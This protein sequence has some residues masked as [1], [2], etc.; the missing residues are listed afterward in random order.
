MIDLAYSG[1]RDRIN[2]RIVYCRS[3]DDNNELPILALKVVFDVRP[4]VVKEDTESNGMRVWHLSNISA[5]RNTSLIVMN[6]FISE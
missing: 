3:R 2:E 4:I 5:K 6:A 1:I